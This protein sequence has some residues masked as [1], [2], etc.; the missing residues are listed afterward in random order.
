[1]H[2]RKYV[3][4]ENVQTFSI[5]QKQWNENFQVYVILSVMLRI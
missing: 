1:M 3:E 5:Q 4:N 2:S